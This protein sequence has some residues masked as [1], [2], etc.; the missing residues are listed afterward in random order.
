MENKLF[1]FVYNEVGVHPDDYALDLAS[2]EALEASLLA[3]GLG[4]FTAPRETTP[5]GTFQEFCKSVAE[6]SILVNKH[7]AYITAFTSRK[8]RKLWEE[9]NPSDSPEVGEVIF[10]TA[11]GR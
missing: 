11:T 5:E 9:C 6:H 10:A 1:W 4:E 3:E 7:L 8:V 2:P